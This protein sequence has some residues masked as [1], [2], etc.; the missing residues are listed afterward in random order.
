MGQGA[1]PTQVAG[2]ERGEGDGGG[3]GQEEGGRAFARG[4]SRREEGRAGTVR[5]VP[6]YLPSITVHRGQP[7][8]KS[9]TLLPPIPSPT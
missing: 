2:A 9:C 1:V 4:C 7:R 8:A 3:G 6:A 5:A